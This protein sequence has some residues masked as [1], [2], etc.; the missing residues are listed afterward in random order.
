MMDFRIYQF[1][2]IQAENYV[3][4]E[5]YGYIYATPTTA[6]YTQQVKKRVD[7]K[8]FSKNFKGLNDIIDVNICD[9]LCNKQI[10]KDKKYYTLLSLQ[11]K[12]NDIIRKDKTKSGNTQF[13][14]GSC[15]SPV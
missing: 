12:M 4:P 1:K 2:K 7:K 11:P 8:Y 10:K 13:H 6:L 9:F 15:F 3:T 14:H 5:K